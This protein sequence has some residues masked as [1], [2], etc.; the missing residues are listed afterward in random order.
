M[1]LSNALYNLI[2]EDTGRK[3]RWLSRAE[4]GEV[5]ENLTGIFLY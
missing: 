2:K 4:K 1:L 5:K 3:E